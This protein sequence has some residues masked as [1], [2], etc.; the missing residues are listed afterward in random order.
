MASDPR[1]MGQKAFWLAIL[2]AMIVAAGLI[3]LYQHFVAAP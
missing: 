3:L 2:F 1:G